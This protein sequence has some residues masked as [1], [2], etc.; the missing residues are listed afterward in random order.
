LN[1][2]RFPV[3]FPETCEFLVEGAGIFDFGP[4]G[5]ATSELRLFFSRTIGLSPNR[6]MIPIRW[7]GKLTGKSRGWT[8]GLLDVRTG[9][10]GTTPSRNFAV[11]RI[12]KDVLSR[13]TVGAIVTNRDS[14]TPGDPYNRGF[15]LDGIFTFLEH[16]TIQSYLAST[17]S[18][19]KN[20][21]NWA[22][23]F[24]AFWIPT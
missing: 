10:F 20:R 7:G 11:A 13:S 3:Y 23:R 18:P 14:R 4:G 15:G 5:G 12:K 9:A 21:D 2:T 6:E 24:R 17:Y 16:F 8:V 22:G 1:L 19:G